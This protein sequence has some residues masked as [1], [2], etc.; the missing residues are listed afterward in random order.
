MADL[1]LLTERVVEK[2]KAAIRQRVEEARKD[3]ED[4]IQAARVKEEQDKIARKLAIDEAA[5][6]NY[7]IRKNTLEI[8]KRNNVLAAKQDILSRVIKDVKDEMNQISEAD[9]KVFLAGVLSQFKNENKVTLVSGEKTVNLVDQEWINENT[10]SDL[11]ATLSNE[12][13]NDEAG[14]LVQKD[15][16][17]YNFLF[18]AL[19]DDAKS[20][21]IPI[22]TKELFV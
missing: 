4:E 13:V 22:I 1:K 15:G 19:I 20:E 5:Q 10:G 3:A 12:T 6:Q 11:Q 14:V 16:I 7:T 21:L 17:E 18:D 9:Y 2:E 8:Q